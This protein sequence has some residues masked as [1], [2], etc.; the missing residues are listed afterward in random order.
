MSARRDENVFIAE[1]GDLL[2]ECA[3]SFNVY[4]TYAA[5]YPAAMKLVHSYQSKPE[6][7]D[8]LQKWMGAPEARGLSLESFLIKPVQRICKYP[9][10][11]R[12]LEKYSE[13]AGNQKDSAFL[14]QAAEKIEGVVS[15]VNEA[16]RAAE[17]KQRILNIGN[18]I[19]SETPLELSDKVYLK[20]GPMFR[21]VNGKMKDRY[22]IVYTDLLIICR[23]V[24]NPNGTQR[25][26]PKYELESG[27]TLA[28]LILQ[29]DFKETV[30]NLKSAFVLGFKIISEE[31]ELL[32]LGTSTAEELNKWLDVFQNAFKDITEEHRSAVRS[33]LEKQKGIERQS[34]GPD[35]LLSF[36]RNTLGKKGLPKSGLSSVAMRKVLMI[37]KAATRKSQLEMIRGDGADTGP[38]QFKHQGVL[39]KRAVAATGH[40]YY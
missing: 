27:Y 39:H 35:M 18:N 17:E 33:T 40:I 22:V 24:I 4:S 29:K 14:R 34:S 7:K 10:L 16:T 28:E 11:I 30:K 25:G 31:N 8:A 38:E 37:N 1:V 3:E 21:M 5:N 6:L 26:P 9:L 32:L 36:G 13:R 23:P 19:E 12:E 2:I 20:D 15:R